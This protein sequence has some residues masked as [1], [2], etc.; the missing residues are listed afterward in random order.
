MKTAGVAVLC[1]FDDI[2]CDVIRSCD[3]YK[4]DFL[5]AWEKGKFTHSSF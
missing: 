5:C 3:Q 4:F 2:T 1:C